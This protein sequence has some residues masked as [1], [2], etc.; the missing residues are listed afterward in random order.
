M[1][2]GAHSKKMAVSSVRTTGHSGNL[3]KG[4][5][6]VAKD[7]YAGKG[8][9]LEVVTDYTTMSLNDK[10]QINVG[11]STTPA[12]LRIK[13]VP[14]KSTGWFQI[15]DII[16]LKAHIPSQTKL[17]TD[18]L[19]V[20]Y[21]G[22]KQDTALYIPE[23]KSAIL[24]FLLYGEVA[25]MFFGQD[26]VLVSK[27]VFRPVG[28]TM[29]EVIEK[30][31]KEL[32]EERVPSTLG[33]DSLSEKLSNYLTIGVIDSSNTS[34]KGVEQ[35][36]YT[37]QVSDNGDSNDLAAVAVQYPLYNVQVL[38]RKEEITTYGIIAPTGTNITQATITNTSVLYEDCENCPA[39][40]TAAPLE[41]YCVKTITNTYN[42]VAGET[43]KVSK[44]QYN[45][46][47]PDTECGASRLAELQAAYPDLVIEEGLAT[48]SAKITATLSGTSGNASIVVDGV[49]YTTAFNTDLATTATAFVTA[50]G[51][52]ILAATGLTVTSAAEV[53][54]FTGAAVGFPTITTVA[55]GLTE[56]ISAIDYIT[57][58]QAGGCKR[59]YSTYVTT[60]AVCN[61]CSD[62]YLQPFYGEAPVEFEGVSWE[63]LPVVYNENAKMGVYIEGKPF[64]MTP[65]I[66]EEDFIPYIETS[67]KI[68]SIS[69]GAS[70]S[71]ILNY[72]GK[73]YDPETEFSEGRQIRYS[74]DVNNNANALFTSEDIGNTHYTNKE[75]HKKNLFAR[76]NLSSERILKYH[77]KYVQYFFTWKDNNLSQGGAS[78]SDI[79]HQIAYIVEY[80]KH[81]PVQNV[82][83]AL[84]TKAGLPTVN[85]P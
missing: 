37:L 80:G 24:D 58:A 29:Q 43:C 56:T 6:A 21:D 68:K 62:I 81:L 25:S 77:K 41:G 16:D 49:T 71:L 53:I 13:E 3:K 46:I 79:T 9:G 17:V 28:T 57:T 35:T 63:V 20:G 39:G 60:N 38:D 22:I 52:A 1:I 54:T 26:E 48:G 5:L 82:L 14:N 69:F 64:Y 30:A 61:E 84:V 23:G 42:W 36:L 12:N 18:R 11:E 7:K 72:D 47:L 44:S 32:K 59:T 40:Y 45:I 70:G 75:K 73:P 83:N 78:R 10:V 67:L 19:E 34:L 51:A 31:V 85:I 55:G 2:H 76:T 50:H 66:Y 4:E 27:E 74:Q 65:E 33:F 8:K 15:K